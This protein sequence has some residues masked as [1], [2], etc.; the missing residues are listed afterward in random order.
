MTVLRS[1]DNPRVRRWHRLVRDARLRREEGRA[2]LEG[3]HLVA[4]YLSRVGAP[5]AI[6]V[7]ASRQAV[8]EIAA[9]IAAGA[10]AG[11]ACVLASTVFGHVADTR[12]PSG[13][14]AEIAVPVTVRPGR[15]DADRDQRIFV[16]GVQ[17]P[18]NLGTL[19]R[20]AAAFSVREA[21]LGPGC[22]DPWSPR[23][24]RAAMGAHFAL[25]LRETADLAQALDAFRG[26]RICTVPTGGTPLHSLALSGSIA[27]I[28]GGEGQGTSEALRNLA[29]QTATIPMTGG[30]ESI[31][32]AVAASICLYEAQRQCLAGQGPPPQ[33]A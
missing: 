10:G 25:G 33:N 27:W 8:P 11:Q 19:L 24:L 31:N 1:R 28:F 22:A 9:L 6:I 14:A 29:D 15:A 12:S 16:E 30:S 21:V 32:V 23:V 2:W 7:D 17:D 3:P 18:G 5:L 20:S 26:I 4:E 13:I